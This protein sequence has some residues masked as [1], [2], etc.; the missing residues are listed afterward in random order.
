MTS[1]P[2]GCATRSLRSVARCRKARWAVT[3]C[4]TSDSRGGEAIP[5]RVVAVRASGAR[6]AVS[7]GHRRTGASRGS[8]DPA[9]RQLAADDWLSGLQ[10]L[11]FQNYLPLDILTKVDRMSMAHSIES[12]PTLLDHRLVEFAA[13]IPVS[14][15]LRGTTT[16]YLF[17]QAMRGILPDAIIDRRK[18]GFAVPLRNGSVATGP[19]FSAIICCRTS[20]GSV[21]SSTFRISNNCCGC[22]TGAAV[23]TCTSGRC[24]PSNSGAGPF[25]IAG[26]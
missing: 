11:D 18:H 12:R 26:R 4:G 24:C 15:R 16:K 22:T 13:T 23:W 8:V 21:G 7:P 6:Q 17:K 10:Y 14:M 9:L 3:F 1:Y 25:S 5:R 20:A 19:A 2:S